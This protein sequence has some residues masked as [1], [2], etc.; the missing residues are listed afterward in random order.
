[1]TVVVVA[2]I[3]IREGHEERALALFRPIVEQTRA[4]PGCLAYEL[5]RSVD[6]PTLFL[7]CE[8]WQRRGDLDHHLTMPYVR[9]LCAQAE[10]VL[11]APVEASVYTP[12]LTVAAHPT[13]QLVTEILVRR[14]DDSTA[15]YTELG[16]TIVRTDAT[17]AELAWEGHRLFLDE[18]P[19]LPP[20]PSTPRANVRVMVSD[21]DEL[22]E[23]ARSLELPVAQA[24]ADRDYG[25]RDF[26]VLDPDGFGVRF[27]AALPLV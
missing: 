17:F 16:F 9:A 11:A 23:R 21:V 24:I 2:R 14:L 19:D 10:G 26:T 3:R 27:A 7:L 12:E 6:D 5:H 13:E 8:A 18:R 4:E 15:F 20:P 25:L 22:W 1:M